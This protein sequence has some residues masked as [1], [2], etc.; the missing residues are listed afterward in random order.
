VPV[1]PARRPHGQNPALP[2][3]SKGGANQEYQAGLNLP[4]A[5]T[6]SPLLIVAKP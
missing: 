5:A 1:R 4:F 6:Q 2:G 3:G